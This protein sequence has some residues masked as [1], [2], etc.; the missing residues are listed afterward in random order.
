MPL[1]LGANHASWGDTGGAKGGVAPLG[2]S[3]LMEV[4]GGLAGMSTVLQGGTADCPLL[5]SLTS[6]G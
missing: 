5:D 6:L 1:C 4:S 2:G 3:D